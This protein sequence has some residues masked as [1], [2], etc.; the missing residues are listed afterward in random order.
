[1]KIGF[2]LELM[3]MRS[4]VSMMRQVNGQ[5]MHEYGIIL[6][7]IAILC[8]ATLTL[9]GK[10]VSQ[11]LGKVANQASMIASGQF[12]SNDEAANPHSAKNASQGEGHI[13]PPT[14]TGGPSKIAAM[15]SEVSLKIDPQTGQVV[16]TGSGTADKNATSVDG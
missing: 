10:N 7:L 8:I 3:Q 12:G 15:P 14:T 9:L 1:M 16:V 5:T 6:A 2:Q 4:R 13:Q 11:L